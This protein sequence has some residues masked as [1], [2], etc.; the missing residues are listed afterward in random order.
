MARYID[1]DLLEIETQSLE[2]VGQGEMQ[3]YSVEQIENAPAADVRPVEHGCWLGCSYD[4]W[5][6]GGY[7]E[8]RCSEC[9]AEFDSDAIDWDYCP[10]C[11]AKMDKENKDD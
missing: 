7:D 4:G 3:F 1:V 9:G 2:D 11:G 8:Y 10:S 6:D 5:G